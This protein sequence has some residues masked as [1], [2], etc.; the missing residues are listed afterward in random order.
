VRDGFEKLKR[1]LTELV[2]ALEH[3]DFDLRALEGALYSAR[4]EFERLQSNALGLH[5]DGQAERDLR[6]RGAREV[7]R[8]VAV[9]LDLA[10]RRKDQ[11][12]A[13]LDRTRQARARQRY[14]DD[15]TERG[16]SCDLDG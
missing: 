13:E 1:R 5:V 16:G 4:V 15:S 14:Y 7:Q 10:A 6:E 11:V 8:L 9:A 2:N 3:G 12:A